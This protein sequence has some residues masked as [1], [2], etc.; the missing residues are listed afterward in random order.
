MMHLE[1]IHATSPS[2]FFQDRNSPHNSP[3][4]E[5]PFVDQTG[6]KLQ[7]YT[8]F[9][10]PNDRTK[11]L[12]HHIHQFVKVNSNKETKVHYPLGCTKA[13]VRLKPRISCLQDRCFNQVSV[14]PKP[15]SSLNHQEV[16][17]PYWDFYI[18]DCLFR[19]L[20]LKRP[21]IESD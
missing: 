4:T 3:G 7:R 1:F 20:Q 9:C 12:C 15:H 17:C 19:R 5:T 8:C 16:F 11:C 14:V 2:F 13:P 18:S 10:L 6:L 21:S